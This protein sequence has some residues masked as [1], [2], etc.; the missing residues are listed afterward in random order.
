MTEGQHRR[1][2][3]LCTPHSA[4]HI[5]V[6]RWPSSP[7]SG[8]QNRAGECDPHTGLHL[9]F[10]SIGVERYTL[11]AVR[12]DLPN[13]NTGRNTLMLDHFKPLIH[14]YLR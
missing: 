4:L 9:T 12:K 2:C 1:R 7:G 8:L 5:Q 10:P 3:A 6:S 13:R 11:M 14:A